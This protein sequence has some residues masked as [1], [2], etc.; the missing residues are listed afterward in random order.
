V[1]P[2]L[3]LHWS[4][5]GVTLN[6][7]A[8]VNHRDSEYT[9][10]NLG[11]RVR[12]GAALQKNASDF[13][14]TLKHRHRVR[15][16]NL[17]SKRVDPRSWTYQIM[18]CS[19]SSSGTE[20]RLNRRAHRSPS[21]IAHSRVNWLRARSGPAAIFTHRLRLPKKMVRSKKNDS[22][23]RTSTQRLRIKK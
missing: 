19:Y 14:I 17:I 6:A 16:L 4:I 7:V 5:R 13:T 8:D 3:Y 1:H 9:A 22:I 20:Q 21:A 11:G 2:N 12:A 18:E 23:L 10:S 15:W